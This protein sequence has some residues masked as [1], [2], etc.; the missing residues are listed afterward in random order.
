MTTT[1]ERAALNTAALEAIEATERNRR[2]NNGHVCLM[3]AILANPAVSA[4]LR[5]RASSQLDRI[6]A[7]RGIRF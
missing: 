2:P 4:P 5:R 1:T 3:S 7:G 6:A